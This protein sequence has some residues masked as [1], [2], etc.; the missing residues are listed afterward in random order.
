[1]KI[2]VLAPFTQEEKETLITR[3]PQHQFNFTRKI[4]QEM[5]DETEMIIGNPSKKTKY[6]S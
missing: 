3:F 2:L 4:T 5:V 1:M 6:K